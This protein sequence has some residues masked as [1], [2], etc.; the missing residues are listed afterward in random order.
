[1]V[2]SIKVEIELQGK[3]L[4][5]KQRERLMEIATKCPVHKTL[6]APVRI[7]ETMKK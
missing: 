3:D 5:D 4:T 7:E 2:D 1:M 6:S